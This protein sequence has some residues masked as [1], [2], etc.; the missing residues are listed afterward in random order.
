M[1]TI[2]VLIFLC[3]GNCYI[4]INIGN[5]LVFILSSTAIFF[6]L[7][8]GNISMRSSWVIF[9]ATSATQ[10]L[11]CLSIVSLFHWLQTSIAKFPLCREANFLSQV[12]SINEGQLSSK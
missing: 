1:L 7:I 9:L 5:F 6:K 2:S 8:L 10:P 3:C 12:F 11:I 4:S